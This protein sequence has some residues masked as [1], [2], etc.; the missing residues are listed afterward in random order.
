M[1]ADKTSRCTYHL[2][3]LGFASGDDTSHLEMRRVALVEWEISFAAV[4]SPD[5]KEIV[6][7]V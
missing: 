3:A 1:G 2:D 6:T 7:S 4:P 5:H